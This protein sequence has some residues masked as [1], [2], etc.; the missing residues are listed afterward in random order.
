[1]ANMETTAPWVA[2]I[3]SRPIAFAQ[4][5]EDATLDQWVVQQLDAEAEVVMVASGGCTA[6][7]LATAPQILRL[8]LIDPNPAQIALSRLK[9]R[10]LATAEPTERLSILG[11]KSMPTSER[12]RRLM[13]ELQS[14]DLPA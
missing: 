4:V 1:M 13:H 14:L 3:A 7:A 10:L 5:R 8:H 2:R 9:L 11:Y 12:R 6:A